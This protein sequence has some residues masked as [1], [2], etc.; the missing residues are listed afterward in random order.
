MIYL[1]LAILTSTSIVI[2]FKLFERFNISI[3]QAITVNYLTASGFGYLS[4]ET[5]FRVTEIPEHPWFASALIVGFTL[6]V[7]FNL[8]AL[9]AQHAGIAVTAISSRMSVVVPVLFGFLL[10]GDSTGWPKLAGILLALVA[11]YFTSKKETSG[12]MNTR[13]FYLP[14]FLFLAFG[15]NDTMLKMAEHYFI[16]DDFTPFLATAFAAALVLGTLVL[17]FKWRSGHEKFQYKNVVA[18]IILGLLNW[19]STLYFLKGIDV[20]EVS[21][22]IP[23]FNTGVVVLASLV[24]ITLFGEKLSKKNRIGIFLAILAIFFLSLG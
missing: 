21:V 3:L 11:F 2:V 16:N 22:F 17:V 19:Y 5:S 18:G 20:S 24:G 9:S 23:A 14:V 13:Y 8:Y 10:F 6:I 15:A 12:Q 1:T 4:S 7:A